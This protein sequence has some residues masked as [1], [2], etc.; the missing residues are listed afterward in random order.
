MLHYKGKKKLCFHFF[1]QILAKRFPMC[2]NI[3]TY[4]YVYL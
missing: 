1:Y 2:I 4:M 3:I